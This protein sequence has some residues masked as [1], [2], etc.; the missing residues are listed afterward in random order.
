MEH[1]YIVNVEGAIFKD[2]RYLLVIRGAGETHAAGMLSLVGGKVENAGI[3]AD[4]LESTVRREILEEVGVEIG[5]VEYV[6]STSFGAEGE[7][8]VDVVFLC[9]ITGGEARVV[10]PD[11]VAEIR[12]MTAAE[13]EAD[14][15]APIWTKNSIRAAEQ[16]R[17]ALR[18]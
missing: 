11:E 6:Q 14:P 4:I 17:L 12:W 16:K 10:D 15:D 8:V 2:G 1:G 13:V 18:W 7:P 9:A 3:S 5:T